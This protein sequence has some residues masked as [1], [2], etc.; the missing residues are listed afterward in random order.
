MGKGRMTNLCKICICFMIMAAPVL[1]ADWPAI[2]PDIWAMKEDPAK[3][4]KDAIVLED[5]TILKN[6]YI[7]RIYRVRILNESGR[8]AA[9][10]NAFSEDCYGF[11]GRTVYPDGKILKFDKRQDFKVQSTE[12]GDYSIKQTVVI[13]PGISGNCVVE[14]RW[15]ESTAEVFGNRIPLPAHMG[16]DKHFY[17][18]SKYM[19]IFESVEIPIP[20][21]WS[22]IPIFG[23][24]QKME[25]IEKSGFRVL[26]ARNIPPLEY[27]PFSLSVSLDRP[28][29]AVFYQPESTLRSAKK[30]PEEYWDTVGRF[31]W[32][33]DFEYGIRKGRHYEALRA[34]ICG[35]TPAGS[36]SSRAGVILSALEKEVI[37]LAHLTY[38]EAAK[39]PKDQKTPDS[40]ELGKMCEMKMASSRGM[41]VL[42]YHL[43]K[44]EGFSPKIA[45]LANRDE[46][47]FRPNMY[48]PWQAMHAVVVV[49]E[50]GKGMGIFDPSQ[51]FA[52]PGLVQPDFQGVRGLLLDPKADW[53]GRPFM[54]P[55]QPS[56]FNER[57]FDYSMEIGEDEDQFKVS[58]RFSGVPELAE[59]RR[60]DRDDQ[61]ERNRK[62]KERIE[63]Q[64]P[65]A[66]IR[67]AEVQNANNPSANVTWDAEGKL[68]REGSR[69]MEIVPFPGLAY[70]LSIPDTMPKERSLPIVMPYLQ[71][72]SARSSFKIPKGYKARN[73]EPFVQQNSF[74]TVQWSTAVNTE[75][76]GSGVVVSLRVSVD[77]MF[78]SPDA[79]EELK[80]YLGW[81]AEAH[82]RTLILE[83]I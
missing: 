15:L 29:L 76:D 16:Y 57:F 59:R 26:S 51:R 19:T 8:K 72:Q 78:A 36:L 14:I 67:R 32:K 77:S 22:Y 28:V 5:R 47:V 53:S 24:T 27:P 66:S 82:R 54:V 44:D 38:E 70:P 64:I 34:K 23:R 50:N 35:G 63:R 48:N 4:I 69:I 2:P 10:L 73:A 62:L 12:I 60:Y 37:N 13:P 45:L 71:T 18:G 81:I 31:L 68:E 33:E 41:V 58:A 52:A 80:A 79:Y 6:T 30:G 40:K 42:L 9:E 74:G 61:V 39:Q 55:I 21:A 3:G 56:I 83:K 20:F 75:G 25:I 46:R 11:D 49:E 65:G 7:E 17:Y 1:R 43:L